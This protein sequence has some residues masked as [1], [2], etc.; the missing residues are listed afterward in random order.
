MA[1]HS[2][3][4]PDRE[5]LWTKQPERSGAVASQDQWRLGEWLLETLLE[6]R[7]RIPRLDVNVRRQQ[8]LVNFLTDC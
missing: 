6:N 8:D 5:S 1:E 2:N 7:A 4:P 3:Q